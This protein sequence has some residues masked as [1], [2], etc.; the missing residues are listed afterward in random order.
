MKHYKFLVLLLSTLPYVSFAQTDNSDVE[1]QEVVVT[2]TRYT[3][4][5]RHTPYTISTLTRNEIEKNNLPSLLPLLGEQVPGLFLTQ[6]GL[7]GFGV[8]GGAAGGLTLRGI[9]S[10]AGQMMV[11]IDGH[12]QYQ[13]IFGHQI[14]DS[15]QSQIAESVEVLRGP[16]S[17]IYGS[18]AM[19]G[20]INIVTRKMLV[21]GVSGYA[22]VGYGSYNTLQS[23]ASVDVKEGKFTSVVSLS[24]NRSDGHR[25]NMEFEQYS[26]LVKLGYE[27]S[28]HWKAVA[29]ANVTHFNSSNPGAENALLLE[30]DQKITRGETSVAIENKYGSTSGAAS[31]FFNFGHH[32]I[33]DGYN[34]LTAKPQEYLFKSDDRLV[35]VSVYESTSLFSGNRIT[36]GF[37]YFHVFGHAWNDYFSGEKIGTT[38]DYADK[39][40][41]ETAGYVDFRQTIAPWFIANAGVR[42]DYSSQT[43]TGE[44]IPSFGLAFP[45]PKNINLKATVSKGFRYA[46]IR[47]LYMFP[48]Q[49]AELEPERLWNYEIGYTQKIDKLS[50]GANIY[51]INADNI[52]QTR[53]IDGKPRNINTG[54]IKN[55]GFE[56]SAAY[57]FN[58]NWSVNSNYSYLDMETPVIAAPEQ[59]LHIS[60][61][62]SSDKL[63]VTTGIDY[64]A[65]LYT[66]L[67][68][69]R[70]YF[71]LWN[72]RASY[73]VLDWLSIWIRLENLLN[74]KYEI[75]AGFPM[76]NTN[77]MAGVK[78]NF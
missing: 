30:A 27:F 56:L 19:G 62:Y 34:P 7:L 1:Y 18:N 45:L 10:S 17:T 42:F 14:S 78:V 26:G 70:E 15:Y 38:S 46:T 54:E 64:I 13:G 75:N 11:L 41:N 59:M 35:G 44:W 49:N 51:Y 77:F 50:L 8:S 61:G 63:F 52:I 68:I 3:S 58:E 47:E 4:D 28:E 6:R 57:K 53:M 73:S 31:F 43:E 55:K 60:G 9:S 76:P 33:N 74:Q 48:P 36:A 67:N 69:S 29:E 2:G 66:D 23:D 72:I 25:D 40:L 21:D 20:V 16:A 22:N 32:N 5:I 24:Y 37:D 39:T 71:T 12:P 65:G